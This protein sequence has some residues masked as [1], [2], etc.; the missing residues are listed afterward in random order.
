MIR[1]LRLM[2]PGGGRR[3]RTFSASPLRVTT[4]RNVRLHR[5]DI[6][7]E[8]AEKKARGLGAEKLMVEAQGLIGVG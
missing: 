4:E 2:F 8:I 1:I 7:Y 5:D 6:N 3:R